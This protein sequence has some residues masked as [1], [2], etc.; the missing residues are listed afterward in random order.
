[1]ASR[2]RGRRRPRSRAAPL[3]GLRRERPEEHVIARL[4]ADAL[5]AGRH[6]VAARTRAPGVDA[7]VVAVGA[8]LGEDVVDDL[9]KRT[10]HLGRGADLGGRLA[11]EPDPEGLTCHAL[12]LLPLQVDHEVPDRVREGAAAVV[13]DVALL[14]P[15]LA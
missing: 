3:S 4:G 8:D 12:A 15:L 6:D 10:V 11:A 13:A 1:G 9:L 7:A 14:L 5:P 2:R